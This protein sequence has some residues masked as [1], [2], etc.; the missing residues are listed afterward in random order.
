MPRCEVPDLFITV[1]ISMLMF[2]CYSF[3][4]TKYMYKNPLLNATE[5]SA[6]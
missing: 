5:M 3:M 4:L 6:E 2:N 1:E